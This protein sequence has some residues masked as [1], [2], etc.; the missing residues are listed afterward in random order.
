M[1]TPRDR[2]VL[3]FH[4]E[5]GRTCTPR[6]QPRAEA[7]EAVRGL[8]HALSPVGF[9]LIKA[10]LPHNPPPAV[11]QTTEGVGARGHVL[12]LELPQLSD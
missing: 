4:R 5:A 2:P 7:R 3:P 12:A 8:L 11:K 9:E 6:D 1:V 10:L